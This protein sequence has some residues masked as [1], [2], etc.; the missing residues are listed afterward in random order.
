LGQKEA[1]VA[2]WFTV[3]A[4][5]LA[6]LFAAAVP[7]LA[8]EGATQGGPATG[9][10][11]VQ[12]RIPKDDIPPGPPPDR[13]VTLS[14]ELKVEGDP[15]PD[16]EFSGFVPAEG[17]FRA[18][19]AD[20]EGDGVYTGSMDV[21]K[22]APGPAPP[23][24]EPVSLPVQIAQSDASGTGTLEVIRDFG[25]VLMDEDKS[26]SASASF[27]DDGGPDGPGDTVTVTFE[28]TIDGEVPEERLLGVDTGIQDIAQPVFC[29]TADFD[30]GLP[31]C[32]DGET[33]GDTF[34]VPADGPFSYE[35]TVLD[36]DFGGVV[37]TF[38]GDTRTFAEDETV[39][40]T[41]R[42]GDPDNN[43]EVIE[44]A[45][46]LERLEATTYQYGTH[47]LTN[48]A[49]ETS[50]ALQSNVVDL[51]G[52]VGERVTLYGALVPGYEDGQVEGGPPL[53]DVYTVEPEGGPGEETV[54]VA[55]ELTVAG[56]PPADATFFGYLGYEPAPVRL[57]DP[58]GDGAYT[59]RTPRGLVPFGDTQPA[60]IVQG[61]GTQESQVVGT[62]PGEPITTI[63]DFGEVTFEEDTTLRASVSFEG[64]GSGNEGA[65]GGFLGGAA[66]SVGD[67]LPTT[68]GTALAVL[69]VGIALVG[70]GLL[71]RRIFR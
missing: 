46:L 11:P 26:F 27:P 55:Y 4:G 47:E 65:G 17:G 30:N 38:A 45:G 69:G 14:F 52:Y 35:Y 1:L 71:V 50:Y 49:G 13:T 15:P 43:V 29:S 39:S 23:G 20:P 67:F 6:V 44:A 70:G 16:A 33:Y 63:K 2:K 22:F 42:P 40:A 10:P 28:L 68:G 19:L 9:P 54:T 48:E 7:A 18:P 60:L 57:S 5:V 56:E 3:L 66:G 58:D 21:P 34:E 41:Y 64:G 53:I 24:T 61:T 59:G 12:E 8:Q 51:D 31:Y 37:E 25:E 62:S 32:E 36:Y